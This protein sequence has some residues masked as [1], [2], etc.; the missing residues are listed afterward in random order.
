MVLVTLHAELGDQEVDNSMLIHRYSV[1]QHEDIEQRHGIGQAGP[2]STPDALARLLQMTDPNQ[3]RQGHVPAS[4]LSGSA[5]LPPY[6][7]KVLSVST[8]VLGPFGM[9][10]KEPKKAGAVRQPGNR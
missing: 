5:D 9:R 1:P 3:Q 2:Q 4:T 10:G 7:W 8:T 6:S